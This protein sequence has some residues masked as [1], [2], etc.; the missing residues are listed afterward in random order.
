MELLKRLVRARIAES[1]NEELSVEDVLAFAPVHDSAS[2][3][4]SP[5]PSIARVPS[6]SSRRNTTSSS[7]RSMASVAVAAPSARLAAFT[8][9]S[10][11]RYVRGTR[12]LRDA[13]LRR[14]TVDTGRLY[15][16]T[17]LNVNTS[18]C[19]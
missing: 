13:V 18:G 4:L 3:S 12:R 16:Q 17:P 15:L 8:F 14:A 7:A 10:V 11:R 19:G 2:G 6:T 1:L 5:T 9:D